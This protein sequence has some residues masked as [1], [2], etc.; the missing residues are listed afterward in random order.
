MVLLTDEEI[1]E[2]GAGIPA[3]TKSKYNQEYRIALHKE[4]A[5]RAALAQ[6]RKIIEEGEKPCPHGTLAIDTSPAMKF[7]C[8]E[9]RQAFKED[10]GGE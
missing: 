5:R 7:E 4:G 8:P 6:A 3:C 9:C 10:I 2:S 1:M